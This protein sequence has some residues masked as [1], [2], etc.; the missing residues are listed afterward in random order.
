[1]A[2]V[3]SPLHIAC[4]DLFGEGDRAVRRAMLRATSARARRWGR[5]FET[6]PRL[7]DDLLQIGRVFAASPRAPSGEIARDPLELAAEAERRDLAL[8]L[9]ALMGVSPHEIRTLMMEIDHAPTDDDREL[10]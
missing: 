9:L 7:A 10:G 2:R 5:A 6:D 3:W 8:E 4:A 1:M